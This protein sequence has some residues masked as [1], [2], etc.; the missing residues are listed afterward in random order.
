MD[1]LLS[2]TEMQTLI[3]ALAQS[4]GATGFTEAEAKTLIEWAQQTRFNVMALDMALDGAVRVTVTDGE[5]RFT[6]KS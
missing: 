2:D 6:A 4:K 1:H 5:V 3:K